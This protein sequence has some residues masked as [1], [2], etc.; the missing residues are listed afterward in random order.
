MGQKEEA[1]RG[2][3]FI[4]KWKRFPLLLFLGCEMPPPSSPTPSLPSSLS[5]IF[6]AFSPPPR[7][8]KRCWKWKHI[9]CISTN[10][11]RRREGGLF[12]AK[13]KKGKN[14]HY[15]KLFLHLSAKK[16]RRLSVVKIYRLLTGLGG[17][18]KK[19]ESFSWTNWPPSSPLPPPPLGK[20]KHSYFELR[21]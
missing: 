16:E 13:R 6:C 7:G 2:P 18:E 14:D 17:K 3:L 1:R 11:Q 21:V 8:E 20:A 10:K 5:V 9:S 19:I 15:Q 12:L 4:A